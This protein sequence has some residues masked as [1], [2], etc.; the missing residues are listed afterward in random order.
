MCSTHSCPELDTGLPEIDNYLNKIQSEE[1]RNN[2]CEDKFMVL[3]TLKGKKT[4]GR[5]DNDPQAQSVCI[6]IK[7]DIFSLGLLC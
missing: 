4:E 1:I 3:E 5:E 2:T 6:F 7:E